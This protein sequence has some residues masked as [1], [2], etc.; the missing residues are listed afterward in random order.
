MWWLPAPLQSHLSPLKGHQSPQTWDSGEPGPCLFS[1][2]DFGRERSAGQPMSFQSRGHIL[3]NR[4][5]SYSNWPTMFK[6]PRYHECE[7]CIICTR[8]SECFLVPGSK[9]ILKH[10]P[11]SQTGTAMSRTLSLENQEILISQQ[12]TVSRTNFLVSVIS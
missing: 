12:S 11:I 10:A 2:P 4:S 7:V 3:S 6:N 5:T 9:I 1:S 8:Y